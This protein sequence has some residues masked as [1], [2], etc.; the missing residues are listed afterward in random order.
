MENQSI[1]KKIAELRKTK[2]WTQ[3]E[4]AEKLNVSDKAVSKW[5][6]DKGIP[7]VEIFPNLAKLFG[8]SIDYIMIGEKN[9]ARSLSEKKQH[10]KLKKVNQF[11]YNS[12]VSDNLIDIAQLLSTNDFKVIKDGLKYPIHKIELLYDWLKN[13]NWKILFR[14]A[15]DNNLDILAENVVNHD[16]DSIAEAI[17]KNYW[18]D[19]YIQHWQNSNYFIDFAKKYFGNNYNGNYG[20]Y[21]FTFD[22]NIIRYRNYSL[23]LDLLLDVINII[24]KIKNE[25]LNEISLRLDKERL[26]GGLTKEY[27][28][29]ELSKGNVELVIIKLCV[30]LEAIL[31]CDYHYEGELSK[32]L[33][34]YCNKFGKVDD[35]WGY[36]V[37]AEFVEKLNRLRIYRNSIVHLENC[38]FQLTNEEINYCIDY[39]CELG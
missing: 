25:I 2:G 10:E 1:G 12:I 39:I 21:R 15:I 7:S 19:Q 37:D 24:K 35:G 33:D 36:I 30:K 29:G 5:E 16:K 20:E 17:L 26:A 34:A 3:L 27:F 28:Y 9:Y 32:M 18:I 23:N 14:Y 4:L 31:R 13:K 11:N 6:K 22:G 8:V 38:N